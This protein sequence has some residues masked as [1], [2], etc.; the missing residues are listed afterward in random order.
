MT[1]SILRTNPALSYIT[2]GATRKSFTPL[3][4]DTYYLVVPLGATREGSYG[5]DSEGLERPQGVT[6]CLPQ[7]VAAC[8]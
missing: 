2:D 5:T 4:S 7:Q 3:A 6:A 1:V 8:P